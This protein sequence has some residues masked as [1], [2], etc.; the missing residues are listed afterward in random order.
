MMHIDQRAEP[1]K[2][3]RCCRECGEQVCGSREFCTGKCR[4]TFHN[5]RKQRGAELYDLFMATRFDR[6]DAQEQG[7]W[8]LLC[9]MAAK[10]KAEDD[11]R[12][13]LKSW[14]PIA[15]VK[16]RHSSLSATRLAVS[17]R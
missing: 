5:R 14:H 12:G 1:R 4:A 6:E 7:A 16:A 2:S 9:R 15:S 11:R 8:S 10:F 17:R 3:L 13:G